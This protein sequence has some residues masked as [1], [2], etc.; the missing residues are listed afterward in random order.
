MARL[1]ARLVARLVATLGLAR[2]SRRLKNAAGA[3]MIA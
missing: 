1:G 3:D 2:I